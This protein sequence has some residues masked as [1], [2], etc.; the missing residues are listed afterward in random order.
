[1][2]CMGDL[3][4]NLGVTLHYFHNSRDGYLVANLGVILHYL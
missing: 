1:M 2:A 4:V 3:K